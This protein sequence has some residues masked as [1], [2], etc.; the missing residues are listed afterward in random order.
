MQILH[1][2]RF[3]LRSASMLRL[4]VNHKLCYVSRRLIWTE[5]F[6][7]YGDYFGFYASTGY[8]VCTRYFAWLSNIFPALLL[9]PAHTPGYGHSA[10][11][12]SWTFAACLLEPGLPLTGGCPWAAIDPPVEQFGWNQSIRYQSSATDRPSALNITHHALRASI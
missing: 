5:R 10:N 4:G 7:S 6:T 3:S 2:P 9:R 12:T 8:L 1:L 11:Q